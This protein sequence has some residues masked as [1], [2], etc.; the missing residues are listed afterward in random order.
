MC[1]AQPPALGFPP[2]P[3]CGAAEACVNM[4][5]Y[6]DP[7]SNAV[8]GVCMKK[9]NVF[10]ATKNTCANVGTTAASCVPTEASGELVVS[11]NGDGICVPQRAAIVARR[12]AVRR[13]RLLPR[14]GLRLGPALH[15]ARRRHRR[16][17]H[18]RV[19]PRL[20]PG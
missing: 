7:N 1:N 9:C 19:R 2:Q 3:E 17:L 20:Q 12:R 8:L 6:T 10:D 5:R 14:R 18:G 4:L 11:T 15:L 13:D 16:D